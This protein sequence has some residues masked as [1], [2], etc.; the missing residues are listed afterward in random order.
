MSALTWQ[1]HVKTLFIQNNG[2]QESIGIAN[3]SGILKANGHDADL[4]LVSHTPDLIGAIKKYDP[5]LIAFS[6]LD[7]RSPLDRKARR[8]DQASA[9]HPDHRR[10]SASDV[11]AGNDF[12]RRHRHHLPGRRRAR[13]ARARRRARARSR[14]HEDPQPARQNAQRHRAQE[15]AASRRAARRAA[16]PRSR[17][18]LQVPV[19]ARHADEAIH[20]EHGLP[21]SV[22]VL[23]RAGHSRS[24][25][26][27]HAIRVR[28]PEVR[29]ARGRR[30]QVHQRPLSAEARALLRRSVLHSQQLQLARRICR[31]VSRGKSG[32]PGTATSATTRSIST[33][34][35]C[36]KRPCATARPLASNPATSASAR[37]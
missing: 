14:R 25:Q 10:R 8:H 11:F 30:D 35:I 17:A 32:F 7:R 22:H 6:A 19:P 24:L 15:R 16:V 1:S 5:G 31:V 36:S 9:Q 26:E 12:R 2:I 3:L 29:G 37:S 27:E 23:P 13:D 21:V 33:P 34:R 18:V 20:L 4:L 28:A